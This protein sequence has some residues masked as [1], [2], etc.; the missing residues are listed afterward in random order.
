[1]KRSRLVIWILAPVATIS[2]LLFIVTA[3]GLSIP[4][5][6]V[7]TRTLRTRQPPEVVWRAIT[8]FEGQPLWRKDVKAVERLP[9]H[10]GR[11]VWRE[12]Y[13]EGSP[14]TLETIE[15]VEPRR[16]VRNIADEGS[17]FSG[18][19]EYD[20]K[21]DGTGSRLVIT[22]RGEVPNPLFRFISRFL[23]GHTYFMERFQ[24]D[25]AARF[26]EEAAIE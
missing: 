3:V 14:I 10:E 2:S 7:A 1:M 17:P 23:I 9:D 13:N 11:E 20:I 12:L 8:D 5:R 16:L 19:W 24:R 25:L 6:H 15:R 22:E 21:P 4:R 18:R 26:G